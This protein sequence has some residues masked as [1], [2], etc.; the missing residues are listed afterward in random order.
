MVK[1]IAAGAAQTV[2]DALETKA[3]A[4]KASMARTAATDKERVKELN[5][6]KRAILRTQKRSVNQLG[7]TAMAWT[8]GCV[9]EEEFAA[10]QHHQRLKGAPYF[11]KITEDM[12]GKKL[13]DVYLWYRIEL[14]AWDGWA[15]RR[16]V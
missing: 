13:F 7:I 9:E 1:T 8:V 6:L 12:A 2:G 11:R 10:R 16:A 15:G 3:L 5:V 4:L 14:S